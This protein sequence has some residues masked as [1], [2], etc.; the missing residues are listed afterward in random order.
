MLPNN[1]PSFFPRQNRSFSHLFLVAL[2]TG[3]NLSSLF[4]IPSFANPSPQTFSDSEKTVRSTFSEIDVR[5]VREVT[6]EE[7]TPI[8]MRFRETVS[9]K[10]AQEYDLI[11][12][13][14]TKEVEVDGKV[15]IKRGAPAR[16][17]VREVKRSKMLGRR[18]KLTIEMWD[19]KLAD[20]RRIPI[21]AARKQKGGGLSAG[22]IVGTVLLS[23]LFLLIGGSHAK[24]EAGTE[25]TAFIDGDWNLDYSKL[26]AARP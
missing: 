23:P 21:R 19:V 25:M 9:S 6:L 13:E 4:S 15:V 18:G 26:E 16:A 7:G 2:L 8:E 12:L 1:A 24:Y 5:P 17:I 22:P 10:V 3:L 11:D 20:G 14:V